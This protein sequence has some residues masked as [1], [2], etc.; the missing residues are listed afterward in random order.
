MIDA[1][2]IINQHMTIGNVEIARR[3]ENWFRFRAGIALEGGDLSITMLDNLL[4]LAVSTVEQYLP[5]MLSIC[6][7]GVTPEH[8]IAKA[9]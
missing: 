4:A 9:R 8:A 5:A 6:F 1:V 3:K 7:A 2:S